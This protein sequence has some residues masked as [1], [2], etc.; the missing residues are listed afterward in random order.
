MKVRQIQVILPY[1]LF[2]VIILNVNFKF[3][4]NGMIMNKVDSYN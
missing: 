4:L 1:F 3:K 2:Y